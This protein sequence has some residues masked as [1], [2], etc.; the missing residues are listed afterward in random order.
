M[1]FSIIVPIY[2]VE[3]YLKKCLDSIRKQSY[4]DFE[5]ILIDDGSNDNS[6]RICDRY[7]EE[8]SRFVVIHKENGGL[9]SAR[10]AG[11]NISRGEYVI[12]IDGDDW[13][14]EKYLFK[15]A[16]II[17]QLHPDIICC[18]SIRYYS[19]NNCKK[20]LIN[21]K[22]GFYNRK[23]IEKYIFPFLVHDSYGNYFPPSVWGKAFKRELYISQQ[24]LLDT[25]IKIGE[26]ISC[27]YP[28][29]FH[30]STMYCMKDCLYFYRQNTQSMT[31]RK[32]FDT[33][34]PKLIG[35]HLEKC[36]ISPQ[37]N[38]RKQID[39]LIVHLLFNCLVT[40]FY[41]TD[42]YAQICNIIN[43]VLNDEYYDNAINNCSY[44]FIYLKGL[45]ALFAMKYRLFFLMKIYSLFK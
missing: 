16:T 17:E 33:Q 14:D 13:I 27:T 10:Q 2:N 22:E 35:K 23:Q 18:S 4:A 37:F 21:V 32:V 9:V 15:F 30:A 41:K 31:H 6:A 24:L 11:A 8:D 19:D 44:S 38:Y 45:L 3:Q 26:D 5:C 39:R 40:Q 1:L 29:I 34:G 42:T 28:C 20:S 36:L 25:N 12:C 43:S 7:C